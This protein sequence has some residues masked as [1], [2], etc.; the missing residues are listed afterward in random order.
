MKRLESPRRRFLLPV[1]VSA[2]LMMAIPALAQ[3]ADS[4]GHHLET[5]VS[6]VLDWLGLTDD[7]AEASD[8]DPE[9]PLPSMGFEIEPNG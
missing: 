7:E 8:D 4:A 9:E 6:S 5:L 2:L 1:L 3:P